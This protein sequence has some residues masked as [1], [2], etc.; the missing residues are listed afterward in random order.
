[1]FYS[2]PGLKEQEGTVISVILYAINHDHNCFIILSISHYWKY[3]TVPTLLSTMYF[4]CASCHFLR[5]LLSEMVAYEVS[6][7]LFWKFPI[8]LYLRT[9]LSQQWD[10]IKTKTPPHSPQEKEGCKQW[11][12]RRAAA[13]IQWQYVAQ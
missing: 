8:L 13:S 1:M 12:E 10:K 2:S 4:Y 7:V 3:A 11:V 9:S 5:Y 6:T